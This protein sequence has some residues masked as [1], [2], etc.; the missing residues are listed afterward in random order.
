M[1]TRVLIFNY[2]K[3]YPRLY[4]RREEDLFKYE[5]DQQIILSFKREIP[6]QLNDIIL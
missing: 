6:Q 5:T 4:S 3:M 2:T 1:H